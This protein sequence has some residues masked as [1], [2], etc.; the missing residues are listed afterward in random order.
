MQVEGMAAKSPSHQRNHRIFRGGMPYRTRAKLLLLAVAAAICLP[1]AAGAA[2]SSYFEPTGSMSIA[3]GPAAAAPLPEG[4]VLLAG[5]QNGTY[6]TE[7]VDLASAEI[8]DPSTGTWSATGSLGAARSRAV[9]APLPDGR[10]LVAGGA[11]KGGALDSA[12]IYDPV[13]GTFSPTDP[14]EVARA[15]AAAASLPDG[16]VLVAG[17]W[18]ETLS[19]PLG[20][21]EIFDPVS[22]EF[23]SAGVGAMVSAR[24]GLTAAAL[25]DGRVLLIGGNS[26]NW[27]ADTSE[28]FDPVTEAFSPGPTMA[29]IRDRPS[30]ATLPD[31]RVLIVGGVE[32]G[33]SLATTE[34]FDPATSEFTL[35]GAPTMLA[36]RYEAGVVPIPGGRLLVAG[37]AYNDN[38]HQISRETA[39]VLVSEPEPVGEETGSGEQP[40][41]PTTGIQQ[42]T[43]EVPGPAAASGSAPAVAPPTLAAVPKPRADASD[44]KLRCRARKLR[45]ICT[46]GFS[47][48][49]DRAL[50]VSLLRRGRV[51]AAGKPTQRND[52]AL[53]KFSRTK[54]L[55]KGEYALT[56]HWNDGAGAWTT[57]AAVQVR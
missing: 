30:A 32:G 25:L 21:A 51:V 34:F 43:V 11:Y 31:G 54:P 47:T 52:R 13:T 26:Q 29:S 37:G 2:A 9:A 42:A 15:S 45:L 38:F 36:Q 55:P 14:L 44:V 1:Q 3:R 28:F 18:D 6:L 20:S 10:V 53:L 48:G 35:T 49:S 23:E 57:Q 5:G 17:G 40:G 19:D 22:E 50:H 8:Y 16:R 4:K 24:Q 41:G 46:L 7:Y 56:V 27:E 33:D 12:E 39:E